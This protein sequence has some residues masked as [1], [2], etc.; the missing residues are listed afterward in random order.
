MDRKRVLFQCFITAATW[1]NAF[2][3]GTVKNENI[4]NHELA[5]ELQN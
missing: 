5:E 2:A 4:S 3:G 1:T